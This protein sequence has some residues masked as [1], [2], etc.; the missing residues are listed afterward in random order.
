VP[1]RRRRPTQHNRR[2]IRGSLR[3]RRRRIRGVHHRGQEIRSGRE[4]AGDGVGTETGDGVA[5]GE[6]GEETG[7]DFV[8]L[9]GLTAFVVVL[10]QVEDFACRVEEWSVERKRAERR[11]LRKGGKERKDERTHSNR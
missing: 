5:A 4:A 6:G 10:V 9:R 1:I 11:K 7:D 2:L 3:S 8:D